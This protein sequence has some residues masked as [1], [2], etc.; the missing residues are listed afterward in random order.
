MAN[1]TLYHHA[2]VGTIV[3]NSSTDV[4]ASIILV[5]LIDF[6]DVLMLKICPI[7]AVTNTDI[8]IS[9]SL[10]MI[11]VGSTCVLSCVDKHVAKVWYFIN[12]QGG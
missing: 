2:N 1:K 10:L 12:L 6:T 8:N 9:A 11:A 4:N 7:L 3:A 5:S